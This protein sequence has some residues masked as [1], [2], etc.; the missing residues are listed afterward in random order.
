V[1]QDRLVE[2]YKEWV[3][4]AGGK[5]EFDRQFYNFDFPGLQPW[6]KTV[7]KGIV[8][9]LTEDELSSAKQFAEECCISMA[10]LD[11]AVEFWKE[12]GVWSWVDN[13]DGIREFFFLK[14]P[15]DVRVQLIVQID[16]KTTVNT[17]DVSEIE[18]LTK[19]G[20]GTVRGEN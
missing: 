4:V 7:F 10:Q 8:Y 11:Q 17:T 14:S 18:N 12:L 9:Y 2:T 1:S 6:Y 20:R 19:N 5:Q 16:G 15:L 3:E 13:P